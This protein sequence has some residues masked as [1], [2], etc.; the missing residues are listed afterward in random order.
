VA[1]D[2]VMFGT[3]VVL[4]A[5]REGFVLE[6]IGEAMPDL[7][8]LGFN[9]DSTTS[10]IDTLSFAPARYS[11][12]EIEAFR[13]MLSL[14]RR[15]VQSR[16]PSF[17]GRAASLSAEINQKYLPKRHFDRVRL[18]AKAADALGYQVAHSGSIV[19]LLFD[20]NDGKAERGIHRAENLLAEAGIDETWHFRT[21]ST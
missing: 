14:L 12:W 21:S 19:G 2:S 6:E 4:F 3:S 17:L 9:S 16:H 13:P 1:S 11:W 20:P 5:H 8:V 10:G 7:E 15:A 18:I